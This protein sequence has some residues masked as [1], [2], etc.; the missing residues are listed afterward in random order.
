[1]SKQYKKRRK[2]LKRLKWR[3]SE[4]L[5]WHHLLYQGRHWHRG[6]ARLLRVHPYLKVCIPQRSLHGRI[7]RKIHDIPCPNEEELKEAYTEMLCRLRC[8]ELDVLRDTMQQRLDFLIEIWNDKCPAT[9]AMLKWQRDLAWKYQHKT[10]ELVGVNAAI[11]SRH[12]GAIV[13]ERG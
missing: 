8:G 2:R 7:H 1:M 13:P 10:N 12:G 5:D 6:Y 9:V 4:R 11:A 3:R